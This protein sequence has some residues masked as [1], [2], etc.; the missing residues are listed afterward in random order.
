MMT[1]A[2]DSTF[3]RQNKRR[4]R[5]T[6]LEAAKQPQKYF[7]S[8]ENVN[9]SSEILPLSETRTINCLDTKF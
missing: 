3:E 2:K 5:L 4:K 9:S 8:N 1:V 6:V 7:I